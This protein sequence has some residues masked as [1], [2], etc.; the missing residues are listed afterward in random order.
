MLRKIKRAVA[1]I[2]FWALLAGTFVQLTYLYRGALAHTRA[3]VSGFY[4]EKKDSLD[5]IMIGTS[6]TFSAFM[7]M[8]AWNEYGMVSYN[9]SINTLYTNSIKY[10]VREALKTQSPKLLIIDIAPFLFGHHS[11]GKMEE[12]FEVPTRYNTDGLSL[13]KNRFDLINEVVPV[14]GD[15]LKFYFDLFYYHGD[16]IPQPA[17]VQNRQHSVSKGY[18]NLPIRQIY[19]KGELEERG[20]AEIVLDEV[21]N[22]AFLELLEELQGY[23]IPILFVSQP[24]L[25][26]KD[27]NVDG[28]AAYMERV[29]GEYGFAFLNLTDYAGEMGID[30]VLDYS[31]DYLHYNSTSAEKITAFLGAYVMENYPIP[32]RRAD[33]AYRGWHE[34]YA[35][36]QEILEEDRR[37]TARQRTEIFEQTEEPEEYL[38]LLRSGY[39]SCC[40]W[41]STES[42]VY[43]DT[44]LCE[45]LSELGVVLQ[46]GNASRDSLIVVDHSLDR[47]TLYDEADEFLLSSSFGEVRYT[48]GV[49]RLFIN[50]AEYSDYL[51]DTPMMAVIVAEKATGKLIDFI[52]WDSDEDGYAVIRHETKYP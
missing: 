31:L 10:Y 22:E 43:L 11:F 8:E 23:D 13:S 51:E 17:S 19:A 32:D 5:V 46:A 16:T 37:E 52:T 18:D 29:I 26:V 48:G 7:P 42:P 49:S 33:E 3:H 30:P 39:V 47:Q 15:R 20:Q 21:N 2:V 9:F 24:Y 34:D 36:W 44:V 14:W 6:A 38:K 25:N 27:R 4:D 50:G 1:V 28:L 40:I 12:A 35:L 41:I 45:R